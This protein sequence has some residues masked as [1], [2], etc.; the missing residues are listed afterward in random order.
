MAT[1]DREAFF[2][3]VRPFFAPSTLLDVDLAYTFAKF[4]HRAQVRNE[5][6]E[7]GTDSSSDHVA[8]LAQW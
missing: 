7:E 4:A 3:R 1:E 8:P 2:A 6:D 5:K